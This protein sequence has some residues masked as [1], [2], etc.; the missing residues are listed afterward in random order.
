MKLRRED[1][2]RWTG[3]AL[4]AFAL[5]GCG[6]PTPA[7]RPVVPS[8][9]K[10]FALLFSQNCS[11]CHGAEGTLGPAPAL[12]DPLFLAIISDEDLRRVVR[13]GR[14][15]TL[16]PPF[17]IDTGGRLTE[18]Q[19]DVI[20]GGIRERWG[21]ETEQLRAQG[22]LPGYVHREKQ[23]ASEEVVGRG[24]KVFAADCAKCHGED[25]KGG[26]HAGAIHDPSY[27]ALTS[28]QTIRRIVI[29]GRPDLG[30]P[31]YRRQ[32]QQPALRAL[33]EQEIDDVVAYIASWRTHGETAST[34]G[35]RK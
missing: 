18:A 10:D 29:T 28:T 17:A 13:E 2:R 3:A 16:M 20:L 27:L 5:A 6:R 19:I 23:P 11:G 1:S 24:A 22:P 14:K 25:G 33:T 12:N 4:V 26:A 7:D 15:G 21:G 8:Q 32:M 34:G 35:E 30:M 31:D 9:V